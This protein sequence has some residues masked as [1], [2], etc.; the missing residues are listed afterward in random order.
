MAGFFSKPAYRRLPVAIQ[1][2]PEKERVTFILL[3]M[4]RADS[5]IANQ[6]G[7]SL[8][9]AREFI[10]RVQETLIKTGALDL[11]Q[12]PVFYQIDHQKR[13]EDT[14]SRP[15][16]LPQ[17][18]MDIADRIELEQFYRVLE[19]SVGQLPRQSRRLLELWFNKDMKVKDILKFY[20]KLGLSIKEGKPIMETTEQDVF[21]ILDKN[22]KN[23]LKIVRSNLKHDQVELTHSALK[24]ILNETGV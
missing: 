11:I 14:P 6:L 20:K 16:E 15:F 18:E 1:N 21:Y 12:D 5:F 7:V 8:T 13:D 10:T 24:A 17:H 3:R 4:K 9:E 22:I 23:L 2:L 19:K